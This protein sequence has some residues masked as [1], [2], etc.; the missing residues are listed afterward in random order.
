MIKANGQRLDWLRYDFATR[1]SEGR[2]WIWP[3]YDEAL[4]AKHAEPGSE[5]VWRAVYCEG[6]QPCGLLSQV[7]APGPKLRTFGKLS[8]SPAGSAVIRA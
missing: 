5:L 6:W 2:V 7:P 3:D 4:K 8:T 1:D